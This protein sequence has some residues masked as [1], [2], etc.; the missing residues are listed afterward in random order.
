MNKVESKLACSTC[1]GYGEIAPVDGLDLPERCE[2]CEG[3]GYGIRALAKAYRTTEGKETE[4]D[5]VNIILPYP[6]YITRGEDT[7]ACPQGAEFFT[8]EHGI[9][10]VKFR[11]RNGYHIGKEHMI[12]TENIIIIRRNNG[13]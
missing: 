12:R 9:Q 8:D 11:P 3:T 6:I 7:W 4:S 2:V 1:N 5:A 10:W 13:D